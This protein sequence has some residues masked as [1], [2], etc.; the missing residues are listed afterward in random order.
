MNEIADRLY[1]SA[2][3]DHFLKQLA[4]LLVSSGS[5]H[6]N[7]IKSFYPVSWAAIVTVIDSPPF[8]NF[9]T[10]REAMATGSVSV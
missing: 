9:S 3:S 1:S 6:D 4:L 5:V 7:D 2:D 8:L 10:P